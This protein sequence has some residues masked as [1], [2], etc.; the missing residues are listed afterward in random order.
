MYIVIY[1]CCPLLHII[2]ILLPNQQIIT[3]YLD[4][5]IIWG[6]EKTHDDKWGGLNKKV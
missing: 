2:C 3:K 4:I 5:L 1:V 6:G